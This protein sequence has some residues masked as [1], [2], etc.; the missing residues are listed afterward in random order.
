MTIGE[1]CNREVVIV[2][3]DHTVMEVAQL[4]RQNHVGDVIVVEDIRNGRIPIGIVTDRDLVVEVLAQ[5]LEP[6]IINMGDLMVANLVTVNESDDMFVAIEA[7]R[8]KGI[9]R[10]PVVDE[11]GGLVGILTLDDLL[12]VLSEDLLAFAKLVKR[13]QENEAKSRN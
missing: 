5:G 1:I 2:Q 9:R 13:E 7:M 12:D 6:E 3:R 8:T 10:M 4:M 11:K